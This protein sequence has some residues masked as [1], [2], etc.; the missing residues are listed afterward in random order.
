MSHS[1]RYAC[2]CEISF[3]VHHQIDRNIFT[4]QVNS[5]NSAVTHDILHK[6]A[7]DTV[8]QTARSVFPLA[9][10]KCGFS[11]FKSGVSCVNDK[12]FN[13]YNSNYMLLTYTLNTKSTHFK[14]RILLCGF[15]ENTA[16]ASGAV[17]LW[18]SCERVPLW[19]ISRAT[20]VCMFSRCAPRT[21][22]LLTAHGVGSTFVEFYGT[23][24]A[25]TYASHRI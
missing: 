18:F 25:E 19:K 8:T 16:L 9:V 21:C 3:R 15:T 14:D 12:H 7:C 4:S 13:T 22:Y 17:S 23:R 5:L 6:K 24:Y 20:S 11:V 1:L 2:S 10:S